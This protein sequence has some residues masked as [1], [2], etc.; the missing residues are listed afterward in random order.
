MGRGSDD[1][2][3]PGYVSTDGKHEGIDCALGRGSSIYSIISGEV[4]RVTAGSTSNLSTIAIYD[5]TNDM[6]VIYLHSIP[7][8]SAGQ[9]VNKGDLVGTES[10]HGIAGSPHTHVEIRQGRN[11]GA[12]K[13]VLDYTQD[14]SISDTYSYLAKILG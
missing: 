5:A 2:P 12:A 13:S 7:S 11:T 6:T 1:S 8:V 14:N 9:Y 10:D 3:K 4:I